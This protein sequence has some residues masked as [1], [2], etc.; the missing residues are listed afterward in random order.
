MISKEKLTDFYGFQGLQ[1]A[2]VIT[3][4]ATLPESIDDAP[5][6]ERHAATTLEIQLY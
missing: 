4:E 2:K 1:I 6:N 5:V 3:G